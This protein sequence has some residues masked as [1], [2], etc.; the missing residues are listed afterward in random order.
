MENFEKLEI[1]P[2]LTLKCIAEKLKDIPY[3]EIS[4]DCYKMLD[5]STED[6][7]IIT[8]QDIIVDEKLK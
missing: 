5:D 2:K 1:V 3:F 7:I 6:E 8:M 4:Y